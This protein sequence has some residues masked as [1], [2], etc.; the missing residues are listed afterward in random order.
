VEHMHIVYADPE[1]GMLRLKGGLGPLQGEPVDGVWTI[2]LEPAE[3]GGTR[4]VWNYAV[5]GLMQIKGGDIGPM[6]DT[7]MGQQL[8]RLVALFQPAVQPEDVSPEL[9]TN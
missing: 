7:V 8:A 3:G 6:V 5:N 9:I 1:R 2:T 4:I